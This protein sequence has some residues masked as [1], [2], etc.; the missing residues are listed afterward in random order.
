MPYFTIKN[1]G[2]NNN[3]FKELC[4]QAANTNYQ[5]EN[6]FFIWDV[7][8]ILKGNYELQAKSATQGNIPAANLKPEE[9]VD[10]FKKHYLNDSG[11]IFDDNQCMPI[12]LTDSVLML[13]LKNCN[14]LTEFNQFLEQ[15]K[16]QIANL[17]LQNQSF[18]S[19]LEK[20]EALEKELYRNLREELKDIG[21]LQSS[22]LFNKSHSLQDFCFA[23]LAHQ[24][25][26]HFK[27][28]ACASDKLLELLNSPKY[29]AL[30]LK[31]C[32]PDGKNVRTRDLR[33]YACH[34]HENDYKKSDSGCFLNAIDKENEKFFRQ[35]F[36]VLCAIKDWRKRRYLGRYFAHPMMQNRR[37]KR[38]DY[39]PS[40]ALVTGHY[41][42]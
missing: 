33:H 18:I 26:S 11:D 28:T 16:D 7:E 15:A 36:K 37:A 39:K 2:F 27:N 32:P 40:A 19:E 21:G 4:F 38:D 1:K 14:D 6:I 24:Q 41:V 8:N 9:I 29:S 22:I 31:I 23:V 25:T 12:N 13:R 20:L 30:A 35:S 3:A 5:S 10:Y 42:P 34:G 17:L